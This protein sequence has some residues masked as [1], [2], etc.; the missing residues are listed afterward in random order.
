MN[1]LKLLQELSVLQGQ[2]V[3]LNKVDVICEYTSYDSSIV[4]DMGEKNEAYP[5]EAELVGNELILK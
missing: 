2:G 5:N 3:D 1:A 4:C